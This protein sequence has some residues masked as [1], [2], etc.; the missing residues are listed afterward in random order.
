MTLSGTNC[1]LVSHGHGPDITLIDTGSPPPSA[2]AFIKLLLEY[3]STSGSVIRD[4]ILTHHHIDHVGGLESVLTSLQ[5]RGAP[6]PRIHKFK[7]PIAN[8]T[9]ASRSVVSDDQLE[10]LVRSLSKN[11][12]GIMWLEHEAKIEMGTRD[13]GESSHLRVLHTPGHTADSVSILMEDTEELF[14]GDTILG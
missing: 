9:P 10:L 4:V 3:L 5:T 13:S 6:E 7:A 14:V 1:Y 8:S 12:N 11:D 2:P